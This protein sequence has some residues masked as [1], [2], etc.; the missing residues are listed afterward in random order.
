MEGNAITYLRLA[1]DY[2]ETIIN[3]IKLLFGLPTNP[4]L[5]HLVKSI[6]HVIISN[7]RGLR[8]TI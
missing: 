7:P 1:I 6:Q 5:S 3:V 2:N 8:V 4:Y